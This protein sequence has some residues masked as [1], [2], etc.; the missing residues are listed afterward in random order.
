MSWRWHWPNAACSY[1]TYRFERDWMCDVFAVVSTRFIRMCRRVWL[2]VC[3]LLS[4][5]QLMSN[6]MKMQS[7][8]QVESQKWTKDRTEVRAGWKTFCN[9]IC[10]FSNSKST[11]TQRR[12]KKSSCPR[13]LICLYLKRAGKQ[14]AS[15]EIHTRSHTHI[16][17]AGERPLAMTHYRLSAYRNHWYP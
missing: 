11:Q 6:L 14:R 7:N 1:V 8:W 15:R 10:S 13:K 9:L 16:T 12:R 2:Y 17:R 3:E 5:I 4:R